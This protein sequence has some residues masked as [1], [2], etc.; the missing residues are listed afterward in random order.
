MGLLKFLYSKESLKRKIFDIKDDM[1]RLVEKIC[2]EKV[3]INSY[4]AFDIDP[5]YLVFWICV[6]T[7]GAKQQLKD[8]HALM[9][10]LRQLLEKH[11]YPSPARQ[12]V[13]ID[14]ESKETVNNK[15]N[16]NWFEHFK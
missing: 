3:W 11:N 5:K 13:K 8:N 16:G 14:F 4:G 7:D 1:K 2:D 6:S 15:S 10:Q 12:L 9:Y